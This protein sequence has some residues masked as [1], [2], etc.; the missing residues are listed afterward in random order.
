MLRVLVVEDEKMIRQGI[1]VMLKRMDLKLGVIDEA[2]NGEEAFAKLR[3]VAYDILLTDIRMPKMDGMALI[4]EAAAFVKVP[5]M[6]VISG[7]DD[8]N[9]AVEALRHGV[10]DYILKPIEREKLTAIMTKLVGE[11]EVEVAD[12]NLDRR[13]ATER[14][15]Q[16]ILDGGRS[17]TAWEKA[18]TPFLAYFQDQA[19]RV[20][21]LT[22]GA[23]YKEPTRPFIFLSDVKGHDLLIV[24]DE[25]AISLAETM[26]GLGMSEPHQGITSI[27]QAFEES[28]N[29]RLIGFMKALPIMKKEKSNPGQ[30]HPSIRTLL[31]AKDHKEIIGI[32]AKS[33]GAAKTNAFTRI[34]DQL[35]ESL[36]IGGLSLEVFFHIIKEV[37]LTIG[38]LYEPIRLVA[39]DQYHKLKNPFAYDT[40]LAYSTDLFEW[41]HQVD[42]ML[43]DQFD[44]Y[45]NQEKIA[46][47]IEY[48]HQHY[49]DDFNMAVVSNQVSMNYSLFS[50]EFKAYTG[51]NFVAYK[52][53][54]RLEAAADLLA[55]TDDKILDISNQIGYDNEK[56]FMKQ[57]KE[58]YGLSPTQY[59]KN[60][61]LEKR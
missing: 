31:E 16:L 23:D 13:M 46:Q 7:Y 47:A 50:Q 3:Q 54:I 14:L 18:T 36:I 9:Y 15:K 11:I 52:K 60:K 48:I 34:Y 38:D 8:F 51:M 40:L 20:L 35:C 1:V 33:I 29:E 43:Q 45:K 27:L 5:K 58:V 21:C 39:Q 10:S 59:R 30:G 22:Q 24:H 12:V 57:F 61:W 56:H 26:M 17:D 25:E 49:R 42:L 28:F 55:Q 19:Y 37:L 41:I 53:K 6:L 2:R 32:M 44:T 4:K